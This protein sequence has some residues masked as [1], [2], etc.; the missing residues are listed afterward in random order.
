[1]SLPDFRRKRLQRERFLAQHGNLSAAPPPADTSA[2]GFLW[3]KRQRAVHI[4][5]GG[6][7][8]VICCAEPE[9]WH[10]H[11]TEMLPLAF[12]SK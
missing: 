9:S 3:G 8:A 7:V 10:Q 6:L 2:A 12:E 4:R 5:Y 1:M 11:W